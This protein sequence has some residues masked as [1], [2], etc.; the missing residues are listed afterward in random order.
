MRFGAA[1][2]SSPVSLLPIV[3]LT[4]AATAASATA[5]VITAAVFR[6]TAV[7]CGEEKTKQFDMEN[8]TK[9]SYVTNEELSN[10]TRTLAKI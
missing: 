3:A 8:E 5:A 9:T 4:T 10:S 1:A 6:A 7:T 2:S